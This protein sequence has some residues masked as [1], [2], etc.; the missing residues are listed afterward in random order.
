MGASFDSYEQNQ[1]AMKPEEKSLLLFLAASFTAALLL[2][3][4]VQN[5][6]AFGEAT[7]VQ[8]SQC[9]APA[10]LKESRD[11]RE[12]VEDPPAGYLCASE[13][14]SGRL[15]AD[16]KEQELSKAG[17]LSAGVPAS[18]ASTS[19]TSTPETGT[20]L[21][22]GDVSRQLAATYSGSISNTT[23]IDELNE[24]TDRT[25]DK[26]LE[27]QELNARF[28]L[29]STRQPRWR[30]WRQFLYGEANS[31]CT[32]AMLVSR[33]A[34]FYPRM[35]RAPAIYT[36]STTTD[37]RGQKTR[38]VTAKF[39]KVRKP[40]ARFVK[41]A[42]KVSM[43]GQSIGMAGDT[44]ELACNLFSY[45]RARRNGLDPAS[46]RKQV[47]VQ[48][49]QIDELIAQRNHLLR[50]P[51]VNK[52]DLEVAQS[53]GSLLQALR[54]LCADEYVKYHSA[55]TK[56][57]FFQN[58]GYVLN[59]AKNACGV[60]STIISL[61]SSIRKRPKM[62]GS[63]GLFNLLAAGIIMAAPVVTR[64]TGNLAACLDRRAVSQDL[65]P[66]QTGTASQFMNDR[67]RLLQEL[68][69]TQSGRS[70]YSRECSSRGK[71]YLQEE[72]WLLAAT[73]SKK[74]EAKKSRKTTTE[75]MI[76][77]TL[78]GGTRVGYGIA[79]ILGGWEYSRRPWVSA[80]LSAASA[81]V[82]GAGVA[83][84]ILETARMRV[85][86][87]LSTRKLK[88]QHLLAGQILQQHMDV[89]KAMRTKIGSAMLATSGRTAQASMDV[90]H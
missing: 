90:P 30:P 65:G 83:C 84:N 44:F 33:M 21:Q 59:I 52:M 14:V 80:R 78:V 62:S 75:N 72:Q 13:Q 71:I 28:K 41:A 67:Q 58:T 2:F 56:L 8:S 36:T 23:D 7:V 60:S 1:Q 15:A 55:S 20:R 6:L 29:S 26:E 12:P 38:K 40:Q 85:C 18:P 31:S 87:E 57:H 61:Q 53:E 51:R 10:A 45:W 35:H 11:A 68:S 34:L 25:L 47:N 48:L 42:T 16:R 81:T 43:V 70:L 32:L 74:L 69:G 76:M 50:S 54:D 27:L 63:T 64:L 9:E 86:Q 82:Y 73:D 46:Y 66:A 39:G 79:G 17:S 89:I 88:K 22:A 77:G 3:P 5:C 37:A 4:P 49:R 24:I 19:T